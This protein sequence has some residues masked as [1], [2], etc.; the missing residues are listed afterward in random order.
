MRVADAEAPPASPAVVAPQPTLATLARAPY[1]AVPFPVPAKLSDK[2]KALYA[3]VRPILEAPASECM[4]SVVGSKYCP[5]Q[6]AS[7][8]A[9]ASNV[10][11]EVFMDLHH[12]Y[13]EVMQTGACHEAIHVLKRFLAFQDSLEHP[14]NFLL[15]SAAPVHAC[16]RHP[17]PGGT[18]CIRRTTLAPDLQFGW[19]CRRSLLD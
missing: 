9:V 11:N 5:V 6:P 19:P 8:V 3:V 14:D 12:F 1:E 18:P 17:A 4:R 13:I 7:G 16:S 2:G 15:S 10:R